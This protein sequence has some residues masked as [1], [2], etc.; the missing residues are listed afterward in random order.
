MDSDHHLCVSLLQTQICIIKKGG[1][2]NSVP[3]FG[4]DEEIV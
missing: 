4:T 3:D 1:G 2:R